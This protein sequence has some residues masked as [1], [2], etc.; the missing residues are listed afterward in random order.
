LSASPAK[1]VWVLTV[2]ETSLDAS[3]VALQP[4]YV[5]H[6]GNAG[7]AVA[8]WLRHCAT[9]QKVAGSIPDGVIEFFS[10]RTMALGLTQPL[11][12]ISN[13]DISWR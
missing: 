2:K 10:G 6:F 4:N 5:E 12:E 7:C 8:Q 13:R 1:N 3:H 9:N 11:T